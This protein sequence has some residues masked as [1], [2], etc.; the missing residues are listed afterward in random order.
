MNK[1]KT[2][3]MAAGAILSIAACQK[4]Q[5]EV[6]GLTANFDL[7]ANPCY[8]GDEIHFTSTSTGGKKPYVCEWK[9]GETVLPSKEE[10]AK[11]TFAKNGTYQVVLSITD[12]LGNTA[13][14]KKIVVVNPAPIEDAGGL[15]MLWVGRMEGYNAVSSPAVADDGSVWCTTRDEGRLYKFDKDGNK[16]VDKQMFEPKN[17][18]KALGIASID[19]DGT[20]F[21]GSGEQNGDAHVI[22][23][24]PDGSEKWSFS[25][26]YAKSGDPAPSYRKGV[27]AIGDKN[28]Y[29]GCCGNSG[30][31][32]SADKATGKRNGF[33][34]PGGGGYTGIALSKDG[35]ASCYG[36]MWG[37]HGVE[38]SV[39]DKGGDSPVQVKYD[40]WM[41][42]KIQETPKTNP[43]SAIAA[44]TLNGKACFAGQVT[45]QKGTRIYAVCAETGEILVNHYV[46]DNSGVQDQGGVVVT[47]E[48][49]LVAALNFTSGQD[50]GGVIMIDP[51]TAD[52]TGK[53][54]VKGR[55]KVQEKV[56]G[57]AAVDKAGNIHFG[58][59][60][61]QYYVLDKNFNLIVKTS[62]AEAVV[63][64][65]PTDF[66]GLEVAK[67]WSSPTIG[68]DGIVYISFTEANTKAFSGV[69]AFRPFN[70]SN[71]KF[72]T[73]L[74]DSE[75]P[76]LAHDR[77]HTSR[78]L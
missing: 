13:S 19:T 30:I 70:R 1:F 58:T 77:R 56:A 32:A 36:G 65:N 11:Y 62:L 51:S 7:S 47:P 2:L 3:I 78:Q 35:Y 57:S 59:E 16:L 8:A 5:V 67:I 9:V 54:E 42:D 28:V 34:L 24:N 29:F 12:D 31:L 37:F 15:E 39:L 18:G 41:S 21:I 61:G 27:V 75:W 76:M 72:C 38:T 66:N 22:A 46:E 52:A 40:L 14:K 44:L 68:D 64:K 23:F 71:T 25:E 6:D 50:D 60:S 20:V 45:D 53:C 48:G 33:C 4:N 63:K 43:E 26:W 69:A 49:Y 74:A 10:E 73:G 17:G 55:F